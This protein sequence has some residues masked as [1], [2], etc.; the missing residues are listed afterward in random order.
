MHAHRSHLILRLLAKTPPGWSLPLLLLLLLPLL[1]GERDVPRMP[2]EVIVGVRVWV[3]VEL[4]LVGG[5]M[6]IA[7]T[8]RLGGRRLA[9]PATA[10]RARASAPGRHRSHPRRPSSR[11]GHHRRQAICR[12][13]RVRVTREALF[14]VCGEVVIGGRHKGGGT[15]WA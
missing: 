5:V 7:I 14:G 8:G 12:Y 1:R 3:S 9:P 13:E 2:V 6:A 4:L 11:R 10:V 15:N